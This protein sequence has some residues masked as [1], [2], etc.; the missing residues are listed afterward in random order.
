MSIKKNFIY[1][2]SYQILIMILP[3]ITT[4]YI[5]RVIGPDGVGVQSYTFSIVNYF[6]LFAMLGINNHGNR[7]IAM[8]RDD[9]EELSKTFGSIYSI[10]IVMTTVMIIIYS[11]YIMFIATEYKTIFCIQVI[12][13]ISALLDINW[14]FFGMEQFKITVVRNIIIKL[15]SVFSIFIFVKESSDLYLY[16]LILALGSLISQIVLWKYIKRYI[17]FTRVKKEEIIHHIKPILI[18]FIPVI[19]I[20]IYKIMDKIMLG[21]MTTITQVGFYENSEKIINIPMGIITALG[22]VMLPKMS[23]LYATGNANESKR[24]MSISMEFTMFMC[25]GAMFGLIGISPILIPIFLG[26]KFIQ[27]ISVVS[28]LSITLVFLSWANVIRTQY[29]IPKK[30][31]KVYIVST[32]LGAIVN[33]IVNLLLISKLGAVG[34]AIGTIF[35]EASVAIFQTI[36]IRNEL[37][38]KNLLKKTVFYLIPGLIM[39]I[40]IRYIG[41][42]MDQSILTGLIQIFIGGF[43]YCLISLGYM[44]IIKNELV[45]QSISKLKYSGVEKKFSYKDKSNK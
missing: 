34:A 36:M 15:I 11:L 43:I 18:L 39:C 9:K 27:C 40:V 35:A 8:V 14:F 30:K 4:P 7:S 17:K 33:V 12:Y 38:I 26:N 19:S 10:Q 31:D 6:V 44:I 28:L 29:L 23:N 21:S 24:Y 13:I 22:T 25:I 2:L 1:N 3:L 5:S 37:D 32:I 16:S 41:E 42:Y 45:V 20:S